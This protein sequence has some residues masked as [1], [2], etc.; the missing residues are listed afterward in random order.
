M[1]HGF[2]S[3]DDPL[4]FLHHA[5]VRKLGFESVS[6]VVLPFCYYLTILLRQFLQVDR[7]FSLWQDH[8][9]HDLVRKDAYTSEHY[10]GDL[11]AILPFGGGGAFDAD[12]WFRLPSTGSFPTP[13]DLLSND[14]DVVRVR[15]VEDALAYNL[16]QVTVETGGYIPNKNWF[17]FPS[18]SKGCRLGRQ[19]GGTGR[20][21]CTGRPASLPLV[22]NERAKALWDDLTNKFDYSPSQ[23]VREVARAACGPSNRLTATSEWIANTAL[24][25]S[26]YRCYP[27]DI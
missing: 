6:R 9:D 12:D 5:N 25:E 10:S 17:T 22:A 19:P 15:Y 23:A 11:D 1:G 20:H 26:E 14:G 4:F 8:Y 2:V 18:R 3:P 7:I 27:D 24:E 13:R 21:A 16:A